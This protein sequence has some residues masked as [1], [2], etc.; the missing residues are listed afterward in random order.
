LALTTRHEN[1]VISNGI[2][3]LPPIYLDPTV[4]YRVRVYDAD[5]EVGVD[6]PLEEYDP[7]RTRRWQMHSVYLPS[8][9]YKNTSVT[10]TLPFTKVMEFAAGADLCNV[11]KRNDNLFRHCHSAGI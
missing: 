5:A 7:L 11:G 8:A 4:T 3:Y 1:P 6:A 9:A 10:I 2:G